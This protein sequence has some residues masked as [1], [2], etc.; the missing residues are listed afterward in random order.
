MTGGVPAKLVK[1][2]NENQEE[3]SIA[4]SLLLGPCQKCLPDP[5]PQFSRD[6]MCILTKDDFLQLL[7]MWA[8][9]QILSLI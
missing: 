9:A 6:R 4:G 8:L 3:D 2:W 1:R 7:K 5:E